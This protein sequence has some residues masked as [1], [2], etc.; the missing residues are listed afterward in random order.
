MD[1]FI[2]DTHF[3]HSAIIKYCNRPFENEKL[4]R[5]V[6]IENW[7]KRVKD[8]DTVYFLGDLAMRGKAKQVEDILKTLKGRK[9][10]IRGNHDNWMFKDNNEFVLDQF[11]E[12]HQ[13]SLIIN[14][15]GKRVYLQHAINKNNP[16][17]IPKR[18]K[19]YLYGHSHGVY[20]AVA[21]D[22]RFLNVCVETLDYTPRTFYE[23]ERCNEI[24]KE[25]MGMN[26]KLF[27]KQLDF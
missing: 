24:Y 6:L 22:T 9:V 21:D 18:C 19:F 7:N 10:L 17:V 25:K 11:D 13:Q 16:L 8:N 26:G 3:Y 27:K 12:V 4:M 1:Y 2:S 5:G 15:D 20:P 14:V 23:L